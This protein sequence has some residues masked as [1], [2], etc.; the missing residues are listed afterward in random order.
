M[1]LA[2]Q[3]DTAVTTVGVTLENASQETVKVG[4]DESSELRPKYTM[5]Q[6]LDPEFRL[7]RT[8]DDDRPIEADI[9]GVHGVKFDE[10]S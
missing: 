3:F 2:Y 8:N 1:W 5:K 6:L 9:R 10:V 7:S 4:N